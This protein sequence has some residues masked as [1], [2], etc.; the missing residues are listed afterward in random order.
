MIRFF[1]LFICFVLF[2]AQV[3]AQ[4]IYKYKPNTSIICVENGDTL[5]LPW[6]GGMNTP[7][8]NQL[9]V[10]LDGF[11]D[12]VIFDRMSRSIQVFVNDG[13]PNQT[14]YSYVWDYENAF[15]EAVNSFMMLR[16]WNC[17]GKEDLFTYAPGGLM[18]FD[19]I[20]QAPYPKF[21]LQTDYLRAKLPSG[22]NSG[23]YSLDVDYNVIDDIDNDGDLD[24]LAFGVFGS[25]VTLWE[26]I[27]DNCDTLNLLERPGCWGNFYENAQTSQI[28]LNQTCKRSSGSASRHAGSTMLTLDM[29]GDG[30]KELILGDIESNQLTMLTNGGTPNDA[31]M[32]A[33]DITFPSNNVP[34]DITEFV[35]SFYIDINNNGVEDFIAAPFDANI[36]EDINN[37][38]LYQNTGSTD[39]P[40]LNYN[41]NDFLVGDQ[42]DLGTG[43]YPKFVDV[44][45][46]GLLDIIAGNLGY[47][48]GLLDYDSQLAY[49]RNEGTATQPEFT[50]I[51]RDYLNL[52]ALNEVSLYPAF[53][54]LNGDGSTDMVVGNRSGEIHFFSNAA[55]AGDPLDLSLTNTNL[56]PAAQNEDLFPFLYDVNGDQVLDLLVGRRRGF[57]SVWINNGTATQPAFDAQ[58]TVDT[59]GGITQGFPGFANY[60]FAEIA[61]INGDTVLLLGSNDGYLTLYGGIE[62]YTANSFPVVDSIRINAGMV[63]SSVADLFDNDTNAILIGQATGG[64]TI[65]QQ[66]DSII[67]GPPVGTQ[68]SFKTSKNVD[69]YLYPNPNSREFQLKNSSVNRIKVFDLSGRLVREFNGLEKHQVIAHNLETGVYLVIGYQ[70]N[71]PA[72]NQKMLVF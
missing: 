49:Y 63:N 26:N 67:S 27:A 22:G 33:A 69:T 68:E 59:L 47:L 58:P 7:Q 56:L 54:D 8:F 19:N 1:L 12:L 6:A 5:S 46:D 70:G 44:D 23:V 64:F 38:W 40:Q 15:P 39:L 55:P 29:N 36:H 32:I 35:A 2:E 16:D 13:I 53:G 37:V 31:D 72:F 17:D 18:V 45:G 57:A 62:D 3:E 4:N 52:S 60:M 14:S 24:F 66:A 61:E 41:R 71:T 65:F 25:D 51:T 43:S 20:S 48:Q 10:N 30:A 21:Q 50:L 11:K 34:V 42:I 9:D 28:M